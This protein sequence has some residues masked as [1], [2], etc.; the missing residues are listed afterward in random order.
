MNF[1]RYNLQSINRDV[2]E[3]FKEIGITNIVDTE[4]YAASVL[5]YPYHLKNTETNNVSFGQASVYHALFGKEPTDSHRALSDCQAL[6]E[7]V[8]NP[9]FADVSKPCAPKVNRRCPNC[10]RI[11]HNKHSTCPSYSSF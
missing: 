3:E 7:I 5:K 11:R 2:D 1:L 9:A 8:Q 4:P 10:D 6:L